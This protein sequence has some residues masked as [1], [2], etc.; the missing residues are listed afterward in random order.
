MG[1]RLNLARGFGDRQLMLSNLLRSAV[2]Y[3]QLPDLLDDFEDLLD[4]WRSIYQHHL[5]EQTFWAPYKG[6]WLEKLQST[7]SILIRMKEEACK[8]EEPLWT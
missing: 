7:Q 4:K 3:D 5:K 8:G 6:M 2:E 1:R